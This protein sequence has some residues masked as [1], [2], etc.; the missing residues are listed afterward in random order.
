MGEPRVPGGTRKVWGPE[1]TAWPKGSQAEVT[2][3]EQSPPPAEPC[4]LWPERIPGPHRTSLPCQLG[5]AAALD[6]SREAKENPSARPWA[7]LGSP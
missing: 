6:S 7:E 3:L 4:S 1:D 5:A 2:H